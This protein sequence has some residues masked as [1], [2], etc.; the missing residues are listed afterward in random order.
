M[1]ENIKYQVY[2]TDGFHATLKPGCEGIIKSIETDSVGYKFIYGVNGK[3]QNVHL[4]MPINF[5]VRGEL[6]LRNGT[7]ILALGKCP[8]EELEGIAKHILSPLYESN[9]IGDI[10]E[11]VVDEENPFEQVVYELDQLRLLEI[12]KSN[13]GNNRHHE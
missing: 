1:T 13:N 5:Y 4:P 7:D 3:K 11:Q 9:Q 6:G 8:Q 12:N 10:M 2:N